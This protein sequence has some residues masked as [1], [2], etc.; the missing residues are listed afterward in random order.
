MS[1]L[2]DPGAIFDRKENEPHNVLGTYQKAFLEHSISEQKGVSRTMFQVTSRR[3]FLE[4]FSLCIKECKGKKTRKR[5][6]E[7]KEQKD[8]EQT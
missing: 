3:T 5:E 4:H 6:K 2:V 7:G 8:K 1:L